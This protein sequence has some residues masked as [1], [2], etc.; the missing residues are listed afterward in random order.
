[1]CKLLPVYV[2]VSC[3]GGVNHSVC[4]FGEGVFS[5]YVYKQFSSVNHWMHVCLHIFSNFVNWSY[6]MERANGVCVCL[7]SFV[8]VFGKGCS[9]RMHLL[10]VAFMEIGIQ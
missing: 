10:L 6:C 7:R 9:C 5:L 4:V 1:M 2:C 8:R 3:C